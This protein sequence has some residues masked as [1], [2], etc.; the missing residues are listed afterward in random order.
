MIPDYTVVIAVDE[1]H[2][3]ELELVWPNWCEK[4]P[5]IRDRPIIVI[6]DD[7]L[8]SDAFVRAENVFQK[9]SSKNLM[10]I[11][12]W[13]GVLRKEIAYENDPSTRFGNAQRYRMLSSF[14]HVPAM[15]VE[16]PYWLKL[17]LDAVATGIDDWIQEEWFEGSPAIIASGWGYTKPANQML[18]LDKWAENIAFRSEPLNLAPEPGSS[19]VRHSRIISWCGFFSTGFT[20]Y[21]SEMATMTCGLG[22]LPCPSQDGFMWYVAQRSGLKINTVRMKNFGWKH[23]SKESDVRQSLLE[24]T[25]A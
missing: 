22:K 8:S 4:K 16:T 20:K 24:M 17:D 25:N 9:H 5:S 13:P 12:F 21:C 6:L 3:S 14:V 7:Q 19:L 23:C 18:E 10:T 15:C 2:V 11:V 1:K